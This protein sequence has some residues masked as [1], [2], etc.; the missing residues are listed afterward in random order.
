[1]MQHPDG[2]QLCGPAP[3]RWCPVLVFSDSVI[4]GAHCKRNSASTTIAMPK[5]HG[6][7]KIKPHLALRPFPNVG[8]LQRSSERG[9]FLPECVLFA[10][11][12]Y[13]AHI[14]VGQE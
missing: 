11:Q 9:M 4:Y 12:R 7:P 14:P 6:G 8:P 1:M 10:T 5:S 3:N 2:L 13:R